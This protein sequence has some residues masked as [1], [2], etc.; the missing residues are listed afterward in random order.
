M[1]TEQHL[2]VGAKW[3]V[4]LPGSRTVEAILVTDITKKTVAFSNELS[5]F[6]IVSKDP[7]YLI[8]D[9]KWIECIQDAPI[10]ADTGRSVVVNVLE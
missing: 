5:V 7:R 2:K 4:K 8:S 1:S 3:Y 9:I 10:A 6:G